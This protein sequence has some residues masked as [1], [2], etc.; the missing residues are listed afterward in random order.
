MTS[1]EKRKDGLGMAILIVLH[2]FIQDCHLHVP[3]PRSDHLLIVTIYARD[4]RSHVDILTKV[5]P[6]NIT[7]QNS[8]HK[9]VK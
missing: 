8:N 3:S 9:E 1:G 5:C 6:I 4:M 2:M 7:N